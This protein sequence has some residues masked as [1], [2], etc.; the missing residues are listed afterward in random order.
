MSI[1]SIWSIQIQWNTLLPGQMRY[2]STRKVGV[3]WVQGQHGYVANPGLTSFCVNNNV[4]H[5]TA[6][7][8]HHQVPTSEWYIFFLSSACWQC[9]K[10]IHIMPKCKH[11]YNR[12]TVRLFWVQEM[13]LGS[14][15]VLVT[16]YK[17]GVVRR[18]RKLSTR[19]GGRGT[20]HL[21]F[22]TSMPLVVRSAKSA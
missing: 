21:D 13:L 4:Y 1:W 10:P 20:H 12:S 3:L 14:S 5:Q 15:R 7:H 9:P 6:V 19:R 11:T 8:Q 16:V 17:P 2:L 18:N 22:K